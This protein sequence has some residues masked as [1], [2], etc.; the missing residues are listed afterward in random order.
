MDTFERSPMGYHN[1]CS[2]AG[3][4]APYAVVGNDPDQKGG[5]VLFWAYC[6]AEAERAQQA[7]SKAGYH[8]VTIQE[9][10]K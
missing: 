7:Y 10:R 6:K 2:K 9:Q 4:S 5:G 1:G 8:D 3:G